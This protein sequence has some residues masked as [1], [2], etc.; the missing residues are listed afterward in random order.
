MIA[1]IGPV[2]R[3]RKIDARRPFR[4]NRDGADRRV[5]TTVLQTAEYR[6]HIGDRYQLERP[7]HLLRDPAPQVD[8]DTGHRAVGLHITVRRHVIDGH[9]QGL[10]VTLLR[11]ASARRPRRQA[12]ADA[13]CVQQTTKERRAA[14]ARNLDVSI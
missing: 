5:E 7:L 8:A 3:I 2:G 1:K 11:A 12:N 13:E 10:S 6:F 14:A 9:A 4:R